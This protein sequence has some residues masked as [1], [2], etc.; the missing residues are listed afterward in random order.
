[1]SNRRPSNQRL[2]NTYG[3]LLDLLPDW[4]DTARDRRR[5]MRVIAARNALAAAE[6]EVR[7]AVELA[8]EGG[9]SW[10]TIGTILGVSRQAAHRRFGSPA[11]ARAQRDPP[12]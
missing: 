11:G 4:C 12:G 1:M 8:H 2:P 6:D 3:E 7:R 10:L 9:D 5:T